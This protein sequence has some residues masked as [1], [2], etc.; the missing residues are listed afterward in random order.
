MAHLSLS[1]L[2]PLQV[3]LTGEPVTSFESDKVRALLAYL[4]V[5]ADR[6]HRRESL[7]GLLWP[8]WPDRAARTNL[9]NALANL[10]KAIGDRQA[11]PPFLSITRETIQFNTASDY[12]LDVAAFRALVEADQ[13][14]QP[15]VR[16]LEEAVAL[17]RGS[18]LEGFSLKDSAAFEDW[19]LLTRE[20][21]QRQ[22]LT[23]LHQLAGYYEQRGEYERACEVAWRQV[24]L[25]PWDEEAH[26]QLMRALALNSQRSAALAQYETCCRLL[27][28][29]L[30]VEPAA[31]TT[32][33]YEQIRDGELKALVPF[34]PPALAAQPPPYKGLQ[35]FDQADADL[36][37][38]RE[39]LTAK[40]VAHL[41]PTRGD[42]FLAVVGASGSGKSSI[43]RAGL[44]PALKRSEPLADGT[45]PPAGCT[46]WA[47][48]V[49]TPTAHPLE[50]LAVSLTRDAESVTATTT[51]MDDLA[52]DP[53][54][55]HLHVRRM[56][57]LSPSLDVG[58]GRRGS[59][60]LLVVDQ[61]EELFTLCRGEAERQAFVDNLMA[62]V[63]TDG[64]TVVVIALRADF[65]AHCGQF[66]PLRE[67]LEK[68]QVY[69]G[70]MSAEELRRAV[71]GP[72]EQ[73]GWS[74]ERAGGAAFALPRPAGNV[75]AAT[76]AHADL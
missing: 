18:F 26:Q 12:W 16:Q 64:P 13:A 70:P 39:L 42:R 52:H 22:V 41:A 63:E 25:E 14:G 38:G 69:I 36:F 51:L 29:E 58:E 66:A 28:E 48:H 8:D 65:Y 4:A 55:L 31:E 73:G 49:I 1:L 43:V 20:R 37:F 17:Y 47:V 19:S 72:A 24:E 10:R 67:A 11:R 68:R 15:A 44:I 46:E 32:R 21:F 40:L 6:P 2:G 30:G 76:R 33:L 59:H 53:R 34:G 5:E 71:T 56:S 45:L 3:T 60:L 9:R 50:A 57:S 23:A 54:S 61:F 35:Y 62:A 75:A 74:F 27:A 7:A